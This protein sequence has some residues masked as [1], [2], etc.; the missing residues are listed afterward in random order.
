MCQK[1]KS[2]PI[3]IKPG[4]EIALNHVK[5]VINHF[6]IYPEQRLV[7]LGLILVPFG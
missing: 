2:V 5:S 3:L 7:R 1:T 4:L 6:V